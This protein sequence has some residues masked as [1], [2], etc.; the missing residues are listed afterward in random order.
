MT[1]PSVNGRLAKVLKLLLRIS[2]TDFGIH[3]RQG[4]RLVGKYLLSKISLLVVLVI[5]GLFAAVFEGGT[6]GLLGLAVSVL[7]GEKE[8][9]DFAVLGYVEKYTNAEEERYPEALH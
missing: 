5:T 2:T 7:A 8:S 9:T 6:V 4:L 1:M 3:E